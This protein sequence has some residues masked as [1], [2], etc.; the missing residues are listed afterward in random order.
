M[1]D[2]QIKHL[3]IENSTLKRKIRS[4]CILIDLIFLW[5][6]SIC[7]LKSLLKLFICNNLLFYFIFFEN[8]NATFILNKYLKTRTFHEFKQ[9]SLALQKKHVRQKLTKIILFN[10]E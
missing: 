3:Q 4:L 9:R 2:K 7:L 10:N 8:S 1:K 6:L 5:L